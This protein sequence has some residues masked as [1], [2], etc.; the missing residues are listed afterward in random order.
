[1]S[2]SPWP[3]SPSSRFSSKPAPLVIGGLALN[4]IGDQ[5][6]AFVRGTTAP[7]G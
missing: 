5:V 3:E 4:Q 2:C 1:M 6:L 7:S